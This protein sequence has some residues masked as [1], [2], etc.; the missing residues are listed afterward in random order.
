MDDFNVFFIESIKSIEI[1]NNLFVCYEV[2]GRVVVLV[3]CWFNFFDG[4]RMD[5]LEVI[6]L[7]WCFNSYVIFNVVLKKKRWEWKVNFNYN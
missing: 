3:I 5:F 6:V 2:N 1:I 7:W 4:I